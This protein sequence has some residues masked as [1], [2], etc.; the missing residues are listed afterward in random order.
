MI[1]P[2]KQR[3]KAIKFLFPQKFILEEK[4]NFIENKRLTKI[5]LSKAAAVL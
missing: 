3:E 5:N 2:I 1:L 4:G